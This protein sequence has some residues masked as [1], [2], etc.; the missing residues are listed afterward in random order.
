MII[1]TTNNENVDPKRVMVQLKMRMMR[2]TMDHNSKTHSN[3]RGSNV[4][5]DYDD[6]DNVRD[7]GGTDVKSW[8]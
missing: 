4:D 3:H 1:R 2:I 8:Q 6:I 5:S 7:E